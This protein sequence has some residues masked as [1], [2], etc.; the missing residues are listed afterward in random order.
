MGLEMSGRFRP[1][2][3]SPLCV[4]GGGEN[5]RYPYYR[6]IKRLA[7]SRASLIAE[8]KREMC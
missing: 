8:E 6:I 4:R 2:A 1:V 5:P 3:T 7:G